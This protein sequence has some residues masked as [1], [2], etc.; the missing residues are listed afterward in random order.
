MDRFYLTGRT[1][2]EFTLALMRKD[3]ALAEAFA[4]DYDVPLLTGGASALYRV[5]EGTGLA[6][7]DCSGILALYERAFD[8]TAGD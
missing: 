4:V 8:P 7:L 6:D 2:S 5:A 1:D 3:V